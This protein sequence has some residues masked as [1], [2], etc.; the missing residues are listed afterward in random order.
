MKVHFTAEYEVGDYFPA[1][2]EL[3]GALHRLAERAVTDSLTLGR[4]IELKTVHINI[5]RSFQ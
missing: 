4:K 2:T 1:A 5:D 3:A